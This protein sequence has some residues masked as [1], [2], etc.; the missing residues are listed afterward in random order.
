MV[1]YGTEAALVHSEK[2]DHRVIQGFDS[3]FQ[4]H[5]VK[6]FATQMLVPKIW[7]SAEAPPN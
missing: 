5:S 2:Q 1:I 4:G 7:R 6:A 3:V